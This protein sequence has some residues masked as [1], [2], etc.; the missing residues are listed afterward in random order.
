MML[1][2]IRPGDAS[3]QFSLDVSFGNLKAQGDLRSLAEQ[4]VQRT[5]TPAQADVEQV[6]RHPFIPMFKL[7]R[8]AGLLAVITLL[9]RAKR[10]H[11]GFTFI[12]AIS[13]EFAQ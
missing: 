9:L 10:A 4:S 2:V 11:S 7:D 3:L 12:F 6:C 1:F 5:G 13:F 8:G